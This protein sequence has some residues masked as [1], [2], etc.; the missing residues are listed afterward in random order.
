MEKMNTQELVSALAD[1]QLQGEEL[2]RGLALVT[3]D[4][5]ALDAWQA[6]HLV[7]DV[8]RSGELANGTAPQAFLARL[9]ESLRKE[10]PLGAAAVRPIQVLPAPVPAQAANDPSQRWKLVAGFASVAA[11]A[12]IGWTALGTG[13]KAGGPQLAG[14]PA[15]G[16]AI[17][18][19]A[20]ERGTMLRDPRLDQLMQ[21]H[22]QFGG[23]TA[24][25]S[26]AGFLRNATFEGPA[27]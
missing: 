26:S 21:A 5:A 23:A 25:Q 17:V 9:Q 11:V 1:G 10:Q 14:S 18:L 7:G 27:R 13:S 3:S 8:L 2:A 12:A 4:P 20:T 15:A 24:L 16:Q 6:Y 22:R 19:T